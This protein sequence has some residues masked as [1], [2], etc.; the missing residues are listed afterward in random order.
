MFARRRN[1][2][3]DQDLDFDTKTQIGRELKEEWLRC[4]SASDEAPHIQNIM[5]I[6]HRDALTP[7]PDNVDWMDWIPGDAPAFFCPILLKCTH[8]LFSLPHQPP[9]YLSAH[10]PLSSPLSLLHLTHGRAAFPQMP[11]ETCRQL[12]EK[13]MQ[14]KLTEFKQYWKIIPEQA[15]DGFALADSHNF[16]IFLSVLPGLLQHP[17]H[18]VDGGSSCAVAE[19]VVATLKII[20]SKYCKFIEGWPKDHP[21]YPQLSQFVTAAFTSFSRASYLC[22]P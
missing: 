19:Q 8:G 13:W 1:E 4:K 2:V 9:C 16:S 10:C 20:A 21:Q 14:F 11:V 5:E 7:P 18:K 3:V 17:C 22:D 6:L 15:N 12:M